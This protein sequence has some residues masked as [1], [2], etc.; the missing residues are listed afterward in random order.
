[1]SEA[2][3]LAQLATVNA[4][5]DILLAGAGKSAAV[6]AGNGARTNGG[7]T[8]ASDADL[9]SQYGDPVVKSCPKRWTGENFA[10]RR[11]SETS[12]EFL[13]CVAEFKD[14][15]AGKDDEADA[16]DANGRPKSYW[17][18]M[19]AARARGH[20]KRLRERGPAAAQRAAPKASEW[21]QST[22]Y[23]TTD[24]QIPF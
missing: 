8:V 22:D 24:D 1:M 4:K 18:K 20:A 9:D 2:L 10:G 3:I 19:D 15:Q 13:E 5:L 6:P 7:G 21:E 14:W 17:P 16:K 23:T 12:P 11:Y